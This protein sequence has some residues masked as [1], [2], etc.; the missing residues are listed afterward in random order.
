VNG[1]FAFKR[2]AKGS[3]T[4]HA[5]R[6]F[7]K[8]R[9]VVVKPYYVLCHFV[10]LDELGGCTAPG[11]TAPVQLSFGELLAAVTLAFAPATLRL[12]LKSASHR[13]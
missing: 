10:L 6:V 2:G 11:S 12:C 3:E 8:E 13:V 1:V 9:A 5:V 4:I 7:P